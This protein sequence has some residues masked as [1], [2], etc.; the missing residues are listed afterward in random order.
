MAE[1]LLSSNPYL[2]E[3]G[4]RK[5]SV[6]LSAASSSAIEGIR[7]PFGAVQKPLNPPR[8]TKTKSS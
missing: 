7:R 1:K 6:R 8:R 2:R 5:K 4:A 3:P